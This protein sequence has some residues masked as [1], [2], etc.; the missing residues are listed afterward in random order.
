M[1]LLTERENKWRRF[2]LYSTP[3]TPPSTRLCTNKQLFI[4]YGLQCCYSIAINQT[5]THCS[6]NSSQ[7]PNNNNNNNTIYDAQNNEIP[8]FACPAHYYSISFSLSLS[9]LS[10]SVPVYLFPF[11]SIRSTTAE[12]QFGKFIYYRLWIHFLFRLAFVFHAQIINSIHFSLHLWISRARRMPATHNIPPSL[13][14]SLFFLLLSIY[15]IWCTHKKA[16]LNFILLTLLLL[17]FFFVSLSIPENPFSRTSRS[18][19]SHDIERWR[20]FV[21]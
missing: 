18:L 8:I 5:N 3:P 16:D 20:Y 1:R 7:K 19:W 13:Q 6:Y 17:L 11:L 15:P 2:S 10:I 14:Y 12:S 9:I 21:G 4:Y